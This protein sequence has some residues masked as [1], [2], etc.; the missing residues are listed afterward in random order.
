MQA[1]IIDGDQA[2]E[3]LDA[4]DAPVN[5][6]PER[7]AESETRDLAMFAL[8][9]LSESRDPETGAH[10]ERVQGYSRLLAQYLGTTEKYHDIVDAEFIRLI[11]RASPLHDIGKVGIS[12]SVLLKPGKLTGEEVSI[13][14]AHAMLGAQTLQASLQKFSGVPFLQ[15]A[16]DIA[17]AH[18]ERWDGKG[19]PLGI[20][21]TNIPLCARIVALADVYDA[22]TSRRIYREAISHADARAIIVRERG[23]HFDP[24]IVDAFLNTEAQFLAIK[25]QFRDDEQVGPGPRLTAAIALQDELLRQNQGSQQLNEHLTSLNHRLQKPAV[26]DDLTGLGN[27]RAAMHRL[28]EHWAVCHRRERPVAVIALDIDHFKQVNDQYGHSAGDIV[29]KKVAD[30]LRSCVRSTDIICRVGG[31]EF[32]IVLPS[33][34]LHEAEVCAHRCRQ[35]VGAHRFDFSGQIIRVTLSAGI[36]TRRAD[37]QACA[38]LLRDA[39]TALC[40]AKNAGRNAVRAAPADPI[41]AP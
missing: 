37:M 39:D 11:F 24:D 12:D 22:L 32:L 21:G 28:E 13:M 6:E 1:L 15:M 17:M 30:V 23:A 27:R 8:D 41:A 26:T 36:A 20:F 4:E 7:L 10:I 29:L 38:N 31:E 2:S 18:H 5:L 35:E 34:T 40:A 9:K 3:L 25:D 14:Q 33:Q 16:R 19:Y